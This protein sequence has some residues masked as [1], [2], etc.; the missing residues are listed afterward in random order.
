MPNGGTLPPLNDPIAL[1]AWVAEQIRAGVTDQGISN[2]IKQ[3]RAALKKK[4]GKT[5]YLVSQTSP[6]PWWVWALAA[7]FILKD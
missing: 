4:K 6:T 2:A 1:A 3:A 5:S 7:Y